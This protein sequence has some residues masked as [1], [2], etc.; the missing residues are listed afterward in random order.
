MSWPRPQL[1]PLPPLAH[2]RGGYVWLVDFF[3]GLF[4]LALSQR[5]SILRCCSGFSPV[6][7]I[8]SCSP[9]A[10]CVLLIVADS[11]VEKQGL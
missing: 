8:M 4:S 3:F 7:G 6:V 2:P 10:A 9:V 1:C 11:L 5:S